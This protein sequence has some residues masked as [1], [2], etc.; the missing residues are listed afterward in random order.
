MAAMG[1]E[2]VSD[3]DQEM[4]SSGELVPVAAELAA[5]LETLDRDSDSAA[6]QHTLAPPRLQSG[7]HP[8][9]HLRATAPNR[10]P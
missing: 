7:F 9:S 3:P 5:G 4:G 2:A 10:A 8:I 6:R 1:E